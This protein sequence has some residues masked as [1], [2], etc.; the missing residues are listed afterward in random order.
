MNPHWCITTVFSKLPGSY[1][2]SESLLLKPPPPNLVQLGSSSCR[3]DL[4]SVEDVD[5]QM[6]PRHIR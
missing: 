3:T 6:T 4:P 5:Q 1:T 2:T